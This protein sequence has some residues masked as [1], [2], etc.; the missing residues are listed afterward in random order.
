MGCTLAKHMANIIEPYS[1]A[2]AMQPYVKLLRPLTIIKPHRSTT[3]H[4][5]LLPTEYRGLSV[6]HNSEPC[7]NC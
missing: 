2:A 7:K 1:C 4:G 3:Y 5:L 6:C